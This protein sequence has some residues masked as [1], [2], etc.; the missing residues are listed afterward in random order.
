VSHEDKARLIFDHFSRTLG[1]PP[2]SLDF[3]W[4]ALN[5]SIHPLEDLGLPFSEDEVKEALEDMHADKA[6]GP[7]IKISIA[8]FRSCW[9]VVKADLMA[10]INAFSEL[11][12][13]NFHIINT[14]NVVLLPKKDGAESISDFRPISLIHVVPKI[15][16]K[17]MARRL[18][19]K[20][21]AIVSRSQ[22]AF[23][24]TRTI[25]DNFMYVRNTAC[26]LHRTKTPS[27][28]I[29]LDIDKA[30]DTVRSD[31]MLD[32]LQRLGFSQRWRAL[33][34]TLFSTASSRIILN[35]IPGKDILHG[36][37]LRQ[38]DHLSPLL[39]DIAID[40]LQRL[41]EKATESGLLLL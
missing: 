31:Y 14:A 38:G 17:A 30:F 25:H 23:I 19:P 12:A 1:R 32:L 24:K 16:A 4:D 26:R 5:P 3:N 20:M 29:K 40:P 18:S 15:V 8:F 9:D 37:G 36:H 6:P 35:G 27:L 34:V 33:L 2:R 41:L 21:N 11:L 10:V 39:F 28:L 22:T 13:S 7:Y